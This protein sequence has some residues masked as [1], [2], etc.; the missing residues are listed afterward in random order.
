M[1]SD[2]GKGKKVMVISSTTKK[3]LKKTLLISYVVVLSFLQT[4]AP[5]V[6]AKDRNVS[7]GHASNYAQRTIAQSRPGAEAGLK[8]ESIGTDGH[9]DDKGEAASDARECTTPRAD[10]TAKRASRSGKVP[11]SNGVFK[12]RRELTLA[13]GG[14][15]VRGAAH[16]GVLRV[17]E[18]EGI[19]VD[20][21]VGNSMGA[22]IGGLYCAGVPLDKIEEVVLDGSMKD[23]YGP[24]YVWARVLFAP[25]IHMTYLFRDKPYAGLGSMKRF[26]KFLES[27]IPEDK[28]K[29]G[30]LSPDFS[31]VAM[32][33]TDGNTYVLTD[34]Q[35]SDAICASSAIPLV[36]RPYELGDHLFVDGGIT[37]NLPGFAARKEGSGVIIAVEVN[38]ETEPLKKKVF[39]SIEAVFNRVMNSVLEVSGSDQERYVDLL[40][41]PN[42]NCVPLLGDK[43]KYA[44]AAIE[45]GERAA[46]NSLDK[47]KSML[48]SEP[49]VKEQTSKSD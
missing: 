43:P 34:G 18:K 19:H 8:L 46:T 23:S 39:T 38:K 31:A 42:M 30:E 12:Q 29:I 1:N 35:L 3:P 16:I 9:S 45:E 44:K 4:C 32:N 27:L 7:E 6:I 25:L 11:L 20:H 24:K 15:G 17:L 33:L 22:V 37:S 2:K 41:H 48:S 40:L 14:G 10:G 28:R 13:L 26:K 21:V 36:I 5:Q 49:T 47:I